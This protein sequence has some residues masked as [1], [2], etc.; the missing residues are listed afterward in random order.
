MRVAILFLFALTLCCSAITR[1]QDSV[2]YNNKKSGY[3]KVR[4]GQMT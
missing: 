3:S 2:Q 1:A 4:K